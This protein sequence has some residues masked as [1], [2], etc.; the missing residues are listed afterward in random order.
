M[1]PLAFADK[2]AVVCD[3]NVPQ[4]RIEAAPHESKREP[5]GRGLFMLEQQAHVRRID[6]QAV[7]RGKLRRNL[8]CPLRERVEGFGF[9]DEAELVAFG[10]PHAINVRDIHGEA[11]EGMA[12]DIRH[13]AN[14]TLRS[15]TKIRRLDGSQN[16]NGPHRCGPFVEMVAGDG[17]EPPTRGFSIPFFV[18]ITSP[19]FPHVSLPNRLTA[20]VF[21]Q[22]QGITGHHT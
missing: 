10:D 2:G 13:G 16:E 18:P 17:I 14:I 3:Q 19:R 20:T 12:D 15:R 5:L 6:T 11:T 7:F 4:L 22:S 1:A 21:L 8:P 9:G